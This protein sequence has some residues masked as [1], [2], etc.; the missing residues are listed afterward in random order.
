MEN[1]FHHKS[2]SY[3]ILDNKSSYNLIE[4][5]ENEYRKNISIYFSRILKYKKMGYLLNKNPHAMMDY[6]VST[7]CFNRID[8]YHRCNV[9][10]KDY[11]DN[12]PFFL[13]CNIFLSYNNFNKLAKRYDLGIYDEIYR[14]QK[15]SLSNPVK[16]EIIALALHPDRIMKILKIANDSHYNISKYI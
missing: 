10:D 15:R 8:N 9:C 11:P 1:E 16:D 13:N 6:L 12:Y 5:Q 4:V 2:I 7:C 3:Q 14:D